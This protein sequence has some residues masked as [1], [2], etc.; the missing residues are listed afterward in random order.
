M[1]T[2]F[3]FPIVAALF[4]SAC[5][6]RL[7]KQAEKE[8][9]D[10][11]YSSAAKLYE[12]YLKTNSDDQAMLHLADCY[13]NMNRYTEAE[14]WYAKAIASG[15]ATDL[16]KL[17][18][19]AILQEEGRYSEA[20]SLLTEYLKTNSGDVAA[21]NR[22]AACQSPEQFSVVNPF[23][24]IQNVSF[25]SE[26]DVACFSPFVYKDKMYFTS[27]APLKT[28]DLTDNFSGDGFLDIYQADLSNY[29]ATPLVGDVNSDLHEA[30]PIITPDGN[31]MYF[32]RSRTLDKKPGEAKDRDNHLELCQAQ[33]IDGEWTNVTSLSFNDNEYSCGHPAVTADGKRMF[34]VSDMPGGKGGNDL[35]YSDFSNGTW[36][37][38]VNAGAV[39]TNGNEM[40][41]T[42]R[43][44]SNGDQEF[45]YSTDG[46]VGAGG[47]DIYKCTFSNNLPSD[48]KRMTAPFNSSADD[49]G[50][51]YM[52]D[53][54][55]GYFASNR[56]LNDG[57]DR[58]VEFTRRDPAFFV[59][60][61]VKDKAS[62]TPLTNTQIEVINTKEDKTVYIN[63]DANG[64]F[65]FPSDSLTAYGFCIH[66]PNYFTC[67][68]GTSTPGFTGSFSDTTYALLT[69]EKIVINKP[70]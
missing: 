22:L 41:P 18:Y 13:R 12:N 66:D 21:Q 24:T 65:V 42:I 20:A 39:N 26:A 29:Q 49:F 50:I 52:P 23:Y 57:S 64:S 27:A 56:G 67:F 35:Y 30:T 48:P 1:K 10:Y 25:A 55:S 28:G 7:Y 47:L 16:D 36:S 34:F 59:K 31:T 54:R 8:Y 2:K 61:T 14:Q 53:G 4:L 68:G 32:T 44:L 6:N 60:V 69:P 38:P 33:Y 46:L 15:S 58:I 40:F 62:L 9:G 70:I 17:H 5:G 45:Y 51:V 3:T 63:T 11:Q 37:K 43:T 19:A